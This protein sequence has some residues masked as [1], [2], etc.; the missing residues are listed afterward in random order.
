MRRG[1]GSEQ[2]VKG[3]R[4]N[5]PK[6]PKVSTAALSNADPQNQVRTLTRE[7]EEANERQNATVEVLQV[8]D[9][10]QAISRRYSRRSWK[11]AHHLCAVAHGALHLYDGKMTRAVAVHGLPPA[12]ADHGSVAAG[13]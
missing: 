8:I 2:P 1:G 13:L 7:L 3:R 6:A 5:R 10:S 12:F 4:A 11:K 9:S